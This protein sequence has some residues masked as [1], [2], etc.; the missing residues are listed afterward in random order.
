MAFADVVGIGA[1]PPHLESLS[2]I[3]GRERAKVSA[4][5]RATRASSLDARTLIDA[6]AFL[7]CAVP[8]LLT[9]TSALQ[10]VASS[11]TAISEARQH[12]R[13]NDETEWGTSV[14]RVP[15]PVSAATDTETWRLLEMLDPGPLDLRSIAMLLPA[16]VAAHHGLLAGNGVVAAC[17]PIAL[18]FSLSQVPA[19]TWAASK[20]ARAFHRTV[21]LCVYLQGGFTVFKFVRGDLVG[22]VYE[23][24]QALMGAYATQ[25][26]GQSMFPTYMMCCGFNGLLGLLQIFQAYHGAPL[27]SIPLM[28][29]APP[30]VG[31]T[32][33]FCSWQFCKE[34]AAIAS[35]YTGA[36]S[37]DTCF[38]RIMS[39]DWWPSFLSPSLPP[40][41]SPAGN[42]RPVGGAP[43]WP[44]SSQSFSAFEGDGHRLGSGA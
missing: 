44:G 16:A 40:G 36:G 43:S 15:R 7:F 9:A 21:T 20:R 6:S 1:I 29:V 37:D 26:D 38:V 17:L 23:G 39:A 12:V 41:G 28:V 33:A 34:M 27:R 11:Q 22:G 35:G 13:D 19:D 2:V 10:K 42:G 30:L 4:R 8:E 3:S 24:I 25:P 5:C 32:G 31:L 14:S 18:P